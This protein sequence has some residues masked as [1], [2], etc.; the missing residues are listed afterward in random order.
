MPDGVQAPLGVARDDLDRR[1]VVEWYVEVDLD[2]VDDA[3]HRVFGETRADRQREVVR[4][5]AGRDFTRRTI[6][7]LY[8]DHVAHRTIRLPAHPAPEG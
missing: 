8:G 1:A 2:T 4:R 7:Q 3:D 6:G 5:R